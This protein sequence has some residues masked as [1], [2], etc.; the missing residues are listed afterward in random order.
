MMRLKRSHFDDLRIT[1]IN[2]HVHL[3]LYIC[4]R[5]G[6]VDKPQRHNKRCNKM[7]ITI[8]SSLLMNSRASTNEL[9][10]KVMCVNV[11]TMYNVL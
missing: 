7:F 2:V 5:G 8:D 10:N 11:C 6:R 9:P 3:D 1:N 4:A